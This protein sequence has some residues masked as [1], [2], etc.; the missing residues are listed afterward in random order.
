MFCTKSPFLCFG[1][2]TTFKDNP[3]LHW[4][5]EQAWGFLREEKCDDANSP[6]WAQ[7]EHIHE[8][9][10]GQ[11][12][13]FCCCVQ[14]NRISCF[15]GDWRVSEFTLERH[16]QNNPHLLQSCCCRYKQPIKHTHINK[17][18]KINKGAL[19]NS[20]IPGGNQVIA[21]DLNLRA[22]E[23]SVEEKSTFSHKRDGN[24]Q[25]LF[26]GFLSEWFGW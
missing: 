8:A 11:T 13:L 15:S 17:I 1:S 5:P 6:Q 25:T 22:D 19:N 9:F 14:H 18:E 4:Y 23:S 26:V 10:H 7:L 16:R 3:L 20:P 12:V 21:L 2:S 24:R